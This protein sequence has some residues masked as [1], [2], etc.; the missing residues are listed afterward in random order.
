MAALL[1]KILGNESWRENHLGCVILSYMLRGGFDSARAFLP[2]L[3]YVHL[4]ANPGSAETVVGPPRTTSH[5]ECT[6]EEREA[7]GIPESSVRYS[8]GIEDTEDLTADLDR[9]LAP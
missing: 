4:A 5:V 6:A 8:V 2:R 9:A 1:C 3:E 7:M